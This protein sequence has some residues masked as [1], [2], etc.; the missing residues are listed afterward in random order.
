MME[1]LYWKNLNTC[2]LK[3][4][5]YMHKDIFQ[6]HPI[7][8]STGCSFLEVPGISGKEN[9]RIVCLILFATPNYPKRISFVY[10]HEQTVKTSIDNTFRYNIGYLESYVFFT[11]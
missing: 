2:G 8:L 4:Y 6:N 11:W 9:V 10:S 5:L 7:S 3:E 1:N